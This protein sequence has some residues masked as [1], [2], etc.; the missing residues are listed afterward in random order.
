MNNSRLCEILSSYLD[1]KPTRKGKANPENDPNDN[2]IDNWTVSVGLANKVPVLNLLD[3]LLRVY[4]TICLKHIGLNLSYSDTLKIV[5][6][7][8][9][10]LQTDIIELDDVGDLVNF[11]LRYGHLIPNDSEGGAHAPR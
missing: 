4:V 2:H 3:P 6:S 5:N 7:C 1:R 11:A 10:K 9:E 8:S